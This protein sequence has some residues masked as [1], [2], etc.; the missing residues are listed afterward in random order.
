MTYEQY[1]YGHPLMAADYV[2]AER[3]RQERMNEEAWL[4]GAY[5]KRALESTVGNM[6]IKD[7]SDAIEYPT[8]PIPLFK[9]EE[10]D[11][12]QKQRTDREEQEILFAQAY[13][14][15]MM[16]AGE[17]WGKKTDQGED[18]GSG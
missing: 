7:Q 17:N 16:I 6:F 3:Y 2:R 13:M 5:V 1:W 10:D 11:A 15:Q 12:E 9:D 18:N 8:E 4:H 14:A